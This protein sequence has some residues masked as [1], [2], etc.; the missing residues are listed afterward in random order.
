MYEKRT[1]HQRYL[2][3]GDYSSSREGL[4]SRHSLSVEQKKCRHVVKCV[5]TVTVTITATAT[6][7]VIDNVTRNYTVTAT[8]IAI[9]IATATVT[10]TVTATCIAIAT[11]T[12]TV[13]VTDTVTATVLHEPASATPQNIQQPLLT[14]KPTRRDGGMSNWRANESTKSEHV[15]PDRE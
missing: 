12:V 5:L 7:T 2:V 13:T 3:V 8:C 4:D 9:V 15:R 6:T 10:A 11:V 1:R 14:Q